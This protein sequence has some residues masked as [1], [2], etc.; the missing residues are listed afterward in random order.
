MIKITNTTSIKIHNSEMCMSCK[1]HE[2]IYI[3]DRSGVRSKAIRCHRKLCDNH[4]HK[5]EKTWSEQLE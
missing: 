4:I 2:K 5:T 3:T 1:F